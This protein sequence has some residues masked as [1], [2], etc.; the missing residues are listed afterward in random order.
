M[1]LWT[2]EHQV[3]TRSLQVMLQN[4]VP[5]QEPASR[6]KPGKGGQAALMEFPS[7]RTHC[8]DVIHLVV[9]QANLQIKKQDILHPLSSFPG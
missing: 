1:R 4:I 2:G 6:S 8:S 7:V 3:L 9:L 5:A